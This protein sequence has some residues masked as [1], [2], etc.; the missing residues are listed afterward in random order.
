MARLL[1]FLFHALMNLWTSLSK[2]QTDYK[3][4]IAFWLVVH[5]GFVGGGVGSGFLKNI[6]D[7]IY[8]LFLTVSEGLSLR[9]H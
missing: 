8:L 3:F 5:N 6:S 4:T 2:N 9:E 7:V 1:F